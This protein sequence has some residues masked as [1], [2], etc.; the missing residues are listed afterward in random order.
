MSGDRHQVKFAVYL[1]P[2]DGDK[3]LLSLR[4][5]TGWKDGWYS[6]VAGHVEAGEAAEQAMIREAKEEAGIDV[7]PADLRHAY[8][9]HRVA[10]D[11]TD[12]YVDVFF[13]CRQW[14]GELRNA[15]PE[16]C[17][18][19]CWVTLDSLPENILDYIRRVLT[20]YP[21]GETYSSTEKS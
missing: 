7:A 1:I 21:A 4:Q 20:Q 5:N 18:E 17:G 2:R 14:S 19:L 16:K 13:E 12:E 11:T 9:M 3:V 15:E 6:L 8:T 10:D